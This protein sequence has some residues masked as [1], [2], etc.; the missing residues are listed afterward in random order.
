M[1]VGL[2]SGWV[3]EAASYWG[4]SS[5]SGTVNWALRIMLAGR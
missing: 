1:L 3:A 4:T 5:K 2:V